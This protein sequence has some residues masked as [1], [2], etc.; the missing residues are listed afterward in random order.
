MTQEML[1]H[2][3]GF[4]D[5]QTV[6]AIEAG[7]RRLQP[8]ELAR[9]AEVLNVDV[10]TFT[11]PF[12]LVGEGMFSFRTTTR[13]NEELLNEFEGAAGRW[14]ATY[15]ELTRREGQTPSV[16]SQRLN[17]TEESSYE[18]AADAAEGLVVQWN[19]G[20]VP[21]RRL[22]AAISEQLDVLVLYV[23]APPG[24]SGA[25]TRL[26]DLSAILVNRRE[27]V[28][29]RSYDLAHE[30]FHILTWDAMPPAWSDAEELRRVKGRR[31]EQLANN[32]AAALLMPAEIVRG[33][34]ASRG[35]DSVAAWL[36]RTASTLQVSV[37]ALR[38]RLENLRI[39][40]ASQLQAALDEVHAVD[41]AEEDAAGVL[42]RMFNAQFVGVLYR[43]IERGILSVRRAADVLQIA[44][45]GIAELCASYNL[46]LSHLGDALIG[47]VPQQA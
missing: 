31:V 33:H 47:E 8:H 32:F 15:R 21:A 24:I 25:A 42:P 36:R 2:A 30:L 1:A 29:R 17:L 38:Y 39:I 11:D 14:L 37:L 28:R 5:R 12:R 9:A 23:D 4:N 18:D 34:V 45:V 22:E 43:G 40:V 26:S 44:P 19:L 41:R 46:T 20:D 35:E 16:L 7:E 3:L 6:A 10:E 27:T 13:V